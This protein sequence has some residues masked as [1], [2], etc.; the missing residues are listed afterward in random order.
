[1]E[2]KEG[3][4]PRTA[5]ETQKVVHKENSRLNSGLVAQHQFVF[6]CFSGA[7]PYLY[8]RAANVS[9]SAVNSLSKIG[10][11]FALSTDVTAFSATDL[12]R[13]AEEVLPFL[14]SGKLIVFEGF[15]VQL[16]GK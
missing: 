12:L 9:S 14:S 16:A 4:R 5:K 8:P 10:T 15:V 3:K 1:V 7:C 6:S 13:M 2:A 11:S